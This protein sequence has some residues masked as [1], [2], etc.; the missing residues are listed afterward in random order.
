MSLNI[1]DARVVWRC[2]VIILCGERRRVKPNRV[3]PLLTA[4]KTS[5]SFDAI[6]SISVTHGDSK[7]L[8]K[9][10]KIPSDLP[11]FCFYYIVRPL[12]YCGPM[13]WWLFDYFINYGTL[14][15]N[16]FSS[17]FPLPNVVNRLNSFLGKELRVGCVC[18]CA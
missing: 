4:V 14:R 17:E 1:C 15:G 2:R 3:R 12:Y 13:L 7:S 10:K 18:V 9:K 8:K 11:D 5:V 16:R 6:S